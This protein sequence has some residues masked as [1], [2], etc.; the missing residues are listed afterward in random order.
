MVKQSL[1]KQPTSEQDTTIK[2]DFIGINSRR[3][4]ILIAARVQG[5]Q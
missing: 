1:E 5:I 4:L 3:I 2:P